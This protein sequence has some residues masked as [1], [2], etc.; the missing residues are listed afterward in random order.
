MRVRWWHVGLIVFGLVG[1]VGGVGVV[2]LT[3][4]PATMGL[5]NVERRQIAFFESL[6]PEGEAATTML[7]KAWEEMDAI[8]AE[9][10]GE[11]QGR[12]SSLIA[13]FNDDSN[14]L[15]EQRP[16]GVALFATLAP[17]IDL[18]IEASRAARLV[19]EVR[20]DTVGFVDDY[21]A[22]SNYGWF[23]SVSDGVRAL[24]VGV[25]IAG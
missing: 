6:M 11:A 13:A 15:P 12:W 8:S 5:A 1:L 2:R 21:F 17:G 18:V 3:A 9:W 16:G 14:M 19:E 23:G 20:I 7:L 25:R 4:K 24:W 10:P 22:A